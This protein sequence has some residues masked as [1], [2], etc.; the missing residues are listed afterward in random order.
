MLPDITSNTWAK[1]HFYNFLQRQENITIYGLKTLTLKHPAL[2]SGRC[3]RHRRRSGCR[4]SRQR[5]NLI[6]NSQNWKI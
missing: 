5:D 4:R 2:S 3:S 1:K 6:I